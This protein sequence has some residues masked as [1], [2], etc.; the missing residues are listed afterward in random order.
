MK[1]PHRI[2]HDALYEVYPEDKARDIYKK[3]MRNCDDDF[4]AICIESNLSDA[5]MCIS[6]GFFWVDTPEGERFW[7]TVRGKFL[8]AM[9]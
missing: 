9:L 4:V 6:N 7:K 2:V 3:F 1:T 5:Y 8:E